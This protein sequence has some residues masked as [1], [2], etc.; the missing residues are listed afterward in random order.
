M[1]FFFEKSNYLK[2]FIKFKLAK[3]KNNTYQRQKIYKNIRYE[4]HLIIAL[5]FNKKNNGIR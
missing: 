3:E 2:N 1:K 4:I 5:S